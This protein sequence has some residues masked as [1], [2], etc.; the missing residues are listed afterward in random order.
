MSCLAVSSRCRLASRIRSKQRRVVR[1]F[2]KSRQTRIQPP[3]WDQGGHVTS[4]IAP[5]RHLCIVTIKR[6]ISSQLC[7]RSVRPHLHSTIL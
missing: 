1:Y 2:G 4:L 7:I 5:S 6:P 3:N